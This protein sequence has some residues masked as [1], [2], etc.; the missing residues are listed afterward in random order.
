MLKR[1]L[2]LLVFA[3]AMGHFTFAQETNSSIG[4]IVKG[5]NNE[6]LVGAT[7][8]ATHNPTGTVYRV[9]SRTGGVFNISNIKP[10]S[11]YTITFSFVGFADEK[12]DEVYLSL[13][14]KSNFN[15]ALADNTGNLTEVV[16]AARRA[17][18][19]G[20][21]GTETSIG[22][23]KI[24]GITTVNRNLNDY[25][26]YTPQAKVT[27]DGGISIAGQNN[28]FNAFY[29]DG[30]INNDVFGLAPSGT[31]GG[32]ANIIPISIAAT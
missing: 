21:G 26:K 28:R 31:N 22:R 11:P 5:S 8:T 23:D 6:P 30:A 9:I 13:G 20:R 4:G 7:I 18:S 27:N 15:V 3:L 25:L 17:A 1:I 2:T 19:S 12:R 32:Q 10:G 29:I 16:I 14:Q 24:S